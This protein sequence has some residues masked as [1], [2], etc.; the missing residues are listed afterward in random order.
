MANV[1]LGDANFSCL[2]ILRAVKNDGH[3]VAV[4]GRLLADPCH[5]LADLSLCVDYS[6]LVTFE[7]EVTRHSTQF[8]VAGCNDASYLACAYVANKIG[9][10]GYDSNETAAI[11]HNKV[12]FRRLCLDKGYPAPRAVLL[13]DEAC[14]L[15]FPL[16]YKPSV[17]FSGKGIQ[18]FD[19][20]TELE[21][22]LSS[23]PKVEGVFEEFFNGQLYSHSAFIKDGQILCDF[24]VMEFCTRYPYQVNSSCLDVLLS[25]ALKEDVRCWMRQLCIDLNLVDG[26]VHTQFLTDGVTFSIMEVCRRC[27]GDLYSLLIEKSTGVDYA[28]LY[29]AGFLNN[30]PDKI[31]RS[32]DDFITRHTVSTNSSAI[33]LG[34]SLSG[35]YQSYTFF[36]LKKSGEIIN[37]APY[38]KAGIYFVQH[39]SR[40]QM[41]DRTPEMN[42]LV[43]IDTLG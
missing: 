3:V 41:V 38:D 8:L 6:D 4:A 33:Y 37:A 11:L 25:D 17:S 19:S 40:Q 42:A 5:G 10:P 30:L 12:L 32:R 39:S 2:P 18:R 23:K 21:T 36:P 34:C 24:F 27:P 15:K 35:E 29:A 31:E 9:L 43:D 20:E 1:L 28:G 22:W 26:L 7:N 16:L 14:T 13:S